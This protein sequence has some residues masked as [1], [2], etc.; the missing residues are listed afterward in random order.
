MDA[1]ATYMPSPLCHEITSDAGNLV[2]VRGIVLDHRGFPTGHPIPYTK[3]VSCTLLAGVCPVT[4]TGRA[5]PPGE[6]KTH[7]RRSTATEGAYEAVSRMSAMNTNTNSLAE[8]PLPNS[9]NSYDLPVSY[10]LDA[11][12]DWSSCKATHRQN[13][14]TELP[15]GLFS[16]TVPGEPVVLIFSR[17]SPSNV[18]SNN[19]TMTRMGRSGSIGMGGLASIQENVTKPP[20][21][22][23][24]RRTPSPS[25]VMPPPAPV[26]TGGGRDVAR[27]SGLVWLVE[28]QYIFRLETGNVSPSI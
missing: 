9:G 17:R 21:G 12:Y 8:C 10:Y 23:A 19:S 20:T 6:V 28:V 1:D 3:V 4:R 7:R 26:D 16:V 5:L 11:Q 2:K 25:P 22:N 15:D 18:A 14:F 24:G 13:H 27:A